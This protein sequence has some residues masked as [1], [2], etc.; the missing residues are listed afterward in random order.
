MLVCGHGG[1]LISRLVSTPTKNVSF[2]MSPR[3]MFVDHSTMGR[4]KGINERQDYFAHDHHSF[5][6]I[7]I[8]VAIFPHNYV[9][10]PFGRPTL[11]LL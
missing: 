4:H 6:C 1:Y 9:S 10:L 7:S 8:S 11:V 3:N 5:V 2:I